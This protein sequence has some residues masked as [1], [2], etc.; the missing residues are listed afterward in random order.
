MAAEPVLPTES[1][2][3]WFDQ[4]LGP[5]SLRQFMGH[6][7]VPLHSASIWYRFGGI[8][9]FPFVTQVLTGILLL[10][11]YRPSTTEAYESVQS[12]MTRVK[13]G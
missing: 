4:R 6:K 8:T 1:E 10:F 5:A 13:F 3:G 7:T 11:Y 2:P 9:L 12:I